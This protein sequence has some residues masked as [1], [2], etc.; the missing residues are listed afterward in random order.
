[1]YGTTQNPQA[2]DEMVTVLII[3]DL[4]FGPIQPWLLY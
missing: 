3:G 4:D 2:H 1:M